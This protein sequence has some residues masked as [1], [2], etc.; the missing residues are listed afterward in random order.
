[1]ELHASGSTDDDGER[2]VLWS[3]ATAREIV[4]DIARDIE[5]GR[6]RRAQGLDLIDRV[7]QR[8]AASEPMTR[9]ESTPSREI[10]TARA[11]WA[12]TGS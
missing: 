6:M 8:A 3:A 12:V 11:R 10:A 2:T 1:M 5:L 4:A 7:Q 9:L